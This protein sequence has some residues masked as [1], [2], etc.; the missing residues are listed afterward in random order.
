MPQH[1]ALAYDA[2]PDPST[3]PNPDEMA[4]VMA[5]YM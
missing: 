2:D 5:D 4:Q 3:P 1:A